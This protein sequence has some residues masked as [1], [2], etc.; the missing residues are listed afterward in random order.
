VVT[1]NPAW[2]EPAE[3]LVVLGADH[4]TAHDA[5][6]GNELWRVGGFNPDENKYFRSIASPVVAGEY[7]IA[8]YA[9]GQTVTAIRRGGRGDVTDSHVVWKRE[10]LGADVPT[11]IVHDDRLVICGDKGKV[12]CLD[13]ATGQTHWEEQLPKNRHAYSSSPVLVDGQVL[14]TREDGQ[15]W[16]LSCSAEHEGETR[17]CGEGMI[18]EMTVATPVCVDGEIFLRTHD[19]LWCIGK[20]DSQNE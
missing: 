20:T 3:L 5:A 18:D 11:P 16:W 8:P 19:A 15:S 6:N 1:G 9:R 13:L 17:V 14:L 2:N 4:V 7:V 10:P 12:D